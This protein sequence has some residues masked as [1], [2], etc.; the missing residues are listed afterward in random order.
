MDWRL[1][2]R[3]RADRFDG[4]LE[5]VQAEKLAVEELRRRRH[6][7]MVLRRMDLEALRRFVNAARGLGQ[8]AVG[9]RGFIERRIA[10]TGLLLFVVVAEEGREPL[11]RLSFLFGHIIRADVCWVLLSLF[12]VPM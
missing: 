1:L 7:V 9:D 11:K 8:K 6:E 4:P 3:T 12:P 5:S 2:Y 10:A